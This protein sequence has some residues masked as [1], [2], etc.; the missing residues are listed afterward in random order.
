MTKNKTTRIRLTTGITDTDLLAHDAWLTINLGQKGRQ[1]GRLWF[2]RTSKEYKYVEELDILGGNT[3]TF[4]TVPM[5]IIHHDI[6]FR[7]PAH[8]TF[9]TMAC[10]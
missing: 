4:S 8:A 3:N 1:P 2:Y 9:F 7:N 5:E 10:L 6:Y